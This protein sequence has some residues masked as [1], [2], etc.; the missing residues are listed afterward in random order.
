MLDAKISII[1]AVYNIEKYLP[2]CIDSILAQTYQNLQIILV[3]DGST[4][5]STSICDEYAA[6]DDR[7][8]V[9]HK[10]NGG[11]SD[12]RNA[13]LEIVTGEYVGYVDGDDWI[14]PKMYEEMLTACIKERAEVAVC[15][16]KKIY[17]DKV[18]DGSSDEVIGL[19]PREAWNIYINEHPQYIIYNSV[20]SKLFKWELVK[21]L[22]FP[23]GRNSEDIL[24]TTKAFC[25]MHKCVYLDT[26]YYNYVIDRDGSIMNV[27]SGKRS[28]EDEIPFFYEQI[29]ILRDNQMELVADMAQYQLYRRLLYYY[30]GFYKYKQNRIYAKWIVNRIRNE[31]EEIKK[32]YTKDFVKTGDR[33]RMNLFMAMP[34]WYYSVN[35]FYD[36]VI[37]PLRRYLA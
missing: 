13:G 8:Q 14:E 2:K 7:I 21:D 17:T 34:V 30:L 35:I 37:L 10:R 24:Y 9:I 1:V 33:V 29:E 32:L 27:K 3:D 19:M 36:K 6:K 15:R 31:K 11:L 25:R 12:A 4:D 23:V 16:Y 26:A 28:V 5:A 22:R 18:I 20:W